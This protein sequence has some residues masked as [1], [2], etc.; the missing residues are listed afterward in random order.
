VNE[1]ERKELTQLQRLFASREPVLVND[2]SRNKRA[3][4][5]GHDIV[6]RE[7]AWLVLRAREVPWRI[8]LTCCKLSWC[9]LLCRRAVVEH[10]QE[11]LDTRLSHTLASNDH[12]CRNAVRRTIVFQDEGRALAYD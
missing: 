6:R 12:D 11:E 5:R 3:R 4:R 8:D 10:R 7:Q 2:F 9:S 1:L